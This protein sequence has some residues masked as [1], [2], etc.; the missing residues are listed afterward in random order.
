MTGVQTCALPISGVESIQEV[1]IQTSNFAAEY[2]QAGGGYFNYTMKSGTNQF[3]GSAYDFFVNEFLY[4]GLPFTDR[5]TQ[6]SLYCGPTDDRQH[7]RN[8]V[9][10]NDYGFTLGGPIRI[11]KVYN[12]RNKSFFFFNFE[13]FRQ[14][15]LNGTTTDTVPTQAYQQGNFSTAECSSYIG[16]AAG[17][18]GGACTP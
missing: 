11:P 4:A 10:R 5:C 14:N 8:R 9:R 17:G 18:V 7:I 6:S 2:G 3:H 1:A 13:Q 15:N 16:G 12:G